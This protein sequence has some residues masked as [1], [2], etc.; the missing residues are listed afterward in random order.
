MGSQSSVLGVLF[1][2]VGV[3]H[4][5][6]ER[7]VFEGMC[8]DVN[9]DPRSGEGFSSTPTVNPLQLPGHFPAISS[10]TPT[11]PPSPPRLWGWPEGAL[12]WARVPG[13]I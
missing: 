2:H 1:L 11:P 7:R 12:G 3:P 5:P 10:H 4:P 8:L 6:G 9:R 13:W